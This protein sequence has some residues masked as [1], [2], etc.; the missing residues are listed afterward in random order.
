VRVIVSA[1][2]DQEV[3]GICSVIGGFNAGQLTGAGH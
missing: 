1:F 2:A 3:D